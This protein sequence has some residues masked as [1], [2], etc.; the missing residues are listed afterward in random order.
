MGVSRLHHH[1]LVG[2]AVGEMTHE[3]VEGG[4]GV[5]AEDLIRDSH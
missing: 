4:V 1:G 2:M 3:R 5:K